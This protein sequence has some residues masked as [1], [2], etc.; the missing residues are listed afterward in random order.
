[1][2]KEIWVDYD[3]KVPPYGGLVLAQVGFDAGAG[4]LLA[5]GL[6]VD[7]GPTPWKLQI[8]EWTLLADQAGSLVI[9][10]WKDAYANF[11]PLVADSIAA[12]AKP[13]LT[14]QAKNQSSTLTGWTTTVNAG[15]TLRFNVDSANAISR[16]TLALKCKIIL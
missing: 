13:T 12:A 16:A 5:A 8:Q 11:P 2:A 9:D 6:K 1:M 10:V 15:D 4:E 14:A 3:F 7:W